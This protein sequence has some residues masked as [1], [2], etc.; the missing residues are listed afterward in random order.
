MAA[1]LL[2]GG[3]SDDTGKKDK[4]EPGTDVTAAR[5]CGGTLDAPA[6]SALRRLAGTDRFDES[7]GG[8][9]PN[10]FSVRYTVQHLH[11]EYDQQGVCLIY[12]S[13]D[14]SD[15][16]LL[17]IQF[18]ADDTYPKSAGAESGS[19][20]QSLGVY[21]RT[22]RDGVD[23]YFRCATK[24][25]SSQSHIG[26]TKYVKAEMYSPAGRL[27]GEDPNADRIA[28]LGSISRAVAREAGCAS[29]AGLG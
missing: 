21:T 11:D 2:V 3:C 1:A 29:E 16:P 23:V 6:Q 4:K 25:P 19:G 15:H 5:L 17:D 7:A 9:V 22:G 20:R 12:T 14:G 28:I 8:N 13:G 18:S 27:R 26:D 10:L 24:A